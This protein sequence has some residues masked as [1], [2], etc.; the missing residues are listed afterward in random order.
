MRIFIYALCRFATPRCELPDT[1]KILLKRINV[2]A[3][4]LREI[5]AIAIR[6]EQYYAVFA[7]TLLRHY[8]ILPL[9]RCYY[10][11]PR[12]HYA[13]DAD[14][15]FSL[16]AAITPPPPPYRYFIIITP[17]FTMLITPPRAITLHYC[18]CHY[19]IIYTKMLTHS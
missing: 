12:R 11:T 10:I 3:A 6:A 1:T 19:A 17:H 15:R 4:I 7:I 14:F 9:L 18:R 8:L 2:A 5:Y 16:A 13:I